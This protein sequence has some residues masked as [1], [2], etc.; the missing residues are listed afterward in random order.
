MAEASSEGRT[1]SRAFD[2]DDLPRRRGARTV[3]TTG[4]RATAA[5]RLRL[6]PL[7]DQRDA[8]V[9]HEV[10]P[11][12]RHADLGLRRAD[13]I[14]HDRRVGITRHDVVEQAARAAPGRHR[15]LAGPELRRIGLG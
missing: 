11:E 6:D 13:A 5:A 14:D 9:V 2:L 10:S 4:A 8:F 7:T 12:L 15:R 3:A 1:N